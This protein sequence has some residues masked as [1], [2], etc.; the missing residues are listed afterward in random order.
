MKSQ[1]KLNCGLRAEVEED[2]GGRGVGASE[3]GKEKEEKLKPKR[4]R[5]SIPPY[6]GHSFHD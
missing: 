3:S 4:H 6:W 2:K 5:V 1:S